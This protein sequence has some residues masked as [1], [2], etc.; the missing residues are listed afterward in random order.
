MTLYCG[1]IKIHN[2]MAL[3]QLKLNVKST[4]KIIQKRLEVVDYYEPEL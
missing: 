3:F 2:D 4:I 1:D